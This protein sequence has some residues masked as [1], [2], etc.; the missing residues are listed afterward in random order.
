MRLQRITK[1]DCTSD[2]FESVL[3]EL[4][5]PSSDTDIQSEL[6]T[7]VSTSVLPEEGEF[8]DGMYPTEDMTIGDEPVFHDCA[9]TLVA[10]LFS[11]GAAMF[12]R[13]E[14]LMC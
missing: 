12:S 2:S 1:K 10:S 5:D 3:S 14:S 4:A 13:H 6:V 9:K 7:L 11:V 8:P